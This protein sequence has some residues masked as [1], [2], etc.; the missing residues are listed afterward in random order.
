MA[1]LVG[2]YETTARMITNVV[3]TLLTHPQQLAEL[4][5]HPELLPAAVEELL[6]FVAFA[7][8]L[9]PRVAM[10][11]VQLGTVLV[12]AG[13]AVLCS[14]SS[15]NRDGSVFSQADELNFHRRS[16][17]HVAFGHGPHFCIGAQLARLELQVSLE[18][19][20]Y[21]LPG[22]YIAVSE[23]DLA[24]ETESLIRGLAAFPFAW[25]TTAVAQAR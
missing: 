4:Q 11:D 12:R 10:A 16:N 9:I 1:L 5:T 21:R 18:T 15:A 25:D 24:W 22:L 13:E 17:R 14:N 2:G 20:L 3:Y 8:P 23:D 6:R 7:N 19:I